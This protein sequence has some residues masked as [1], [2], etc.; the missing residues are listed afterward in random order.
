ML[1]LAPFITRNCAVSVCPLRAASCRGVCWW[2][3]T[4]ESEHNPPWMPTYSWLR[5]YPNE[6]DMLNL[7]NNSKVNSCCTPSDRVSLAVLW[8]YALLCLLD[9]LQAVTNGNVFDTWV[10]SCQINTIK[11]KTLTDFDE[12]WFLCSLYWD[13]HPQSVSA[14]YVVWL[15]S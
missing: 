1:I 3:E 13:I 12:S 9:W 2:K 15:K 6:S 11:N 10:I 5:N 7:S 14:L 4:N 8:V